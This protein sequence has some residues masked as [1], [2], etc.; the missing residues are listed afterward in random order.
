MYHCD[1]YTQ[2]MLCFQLLHW[3][4]KMNYKGVWLN[5]HHSDM[6]ACFRENWYQIKK[7][8]CD[9]LKK[10]AAYVESIL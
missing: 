10:V 6:E 7:P 9:K 5:I 2:K 1:N 3:L 4:I 8:N